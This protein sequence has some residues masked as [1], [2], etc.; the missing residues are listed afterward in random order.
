MSQYASFILEDFFR[1]LFTYILQKLDRHGIGHQPAFFCES[2]NVSAKFQQPLRFQ[3]FE[4]VG[5]F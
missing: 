1:R 4:G 5:V 3:K 2:H